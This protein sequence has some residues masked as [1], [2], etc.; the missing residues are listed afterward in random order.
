MVVL[1][2]S[3]RAF[4]AVSIGTRKRQRLFVR[5]L[6]PSG[7][8]DVPWGHA[9]A[10]A[11][12]ALE[13]LEDCVHSCKVFCVELPICEAFVSAGLNVVSAGLGNAMCADWRLLTIGYVQKV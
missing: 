13:A 1:D 6:F 2:S 3:P 12:V 9:S 8:C 10:T 7:R 11:V 4:A 5:T